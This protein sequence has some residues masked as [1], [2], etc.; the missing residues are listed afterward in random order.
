M[1]RAMAV[2]AY[3]EPLASL[4]APEPKLRYGHAL[5]EVLACGVCFSDVKTARGKMPYSSELSLPHIPGHEVCGRVIRTDPAGAVEPG[6]L[7]TVHHYWPC[8]RCA[9]C[10]GGDEQLCLNLVAWMGF[11]D[12]G[13]FQE[14]LAVPLDRL[15][16]LPDGIDPTRAAPMSCALG[17]A[18]R[19]TVT[20]GGVRAGTSAVVLGV[21]GVGIHALQIARAAGATVVGLDLAQRSLESARE[22]GL[23]AERADDRQEEER[24]V[25]QTDGA[26]VDVVIDTVGRQAS[27]AQADRLVRE[28]GRIVGVGYLPTESL[29]MPTPRWV[30]GEVELVGSRYVRRDELDRAVRLVAEGAVRPVVDRV[31]PLEEVNDVFER[32]EA[33]EVAGR[34]VLDVAGIAP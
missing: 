3:G 34:A 1:G 2:T 6:T 31:W 15:V 26:G 14:R 30:L 4:D 9:R 16:R 25:A 24:I 10:H 17:T 13:G 8:G 5:L 32:L 33:G 22:L 21:G 18:Y 20:R 29:S 19:A 11:T 7:V 12:P 23:R 28:G 27:L